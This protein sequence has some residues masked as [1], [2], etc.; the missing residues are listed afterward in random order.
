M[1]SG[2]LGFFSRPLR[3]NVEE[4]RLC[5]TSGMH[6]LSREYPGIQPSAEV[7]GAV[8]GHSFASVV[9][10]MF[11]LKYLRRRVENCEHKQCSTFVK[12]EQD[13]LGSLAAAFAADIVQHA[14]V[15]AVVPRH[16][17]LM[18]C[19]CMCDASMC[20]LPHP[21]TQPRNRSVVKLHLQEDT[22]GVLHLTAVDEVLIPGAQTRGS[23]KFV[24]ALNDCGLSHRIRQ[25]I[26][27]MV[28]C[29]TT[30]NTTT[31]ELCIGEGA[32]GP[33]ETASVVQ[34]HHVLISADMVL[35]M[36]TSSPH[37]MS[38]ANFQSA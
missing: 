7:Q 18:A 30:S 24:E 37:E 36:A 32:D 12:D 14:Q 35:F 25:S 10:L 28:S 2:F 1:L 5:I 33:T 21:C 17:W 8:F 38:W 6:L 23:T 34:P 31:H 11:D 16:A 3:F 15:Y 9:N 13:V 29:H 19:P 27:G 22:H 4:K 20:G 26:R